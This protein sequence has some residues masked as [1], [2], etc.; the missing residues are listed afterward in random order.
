MCTTGGEQ[1]SECE[2]ASTLSTR[3][4]SEIAVVHGFYPSEKQVKW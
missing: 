2:V 4:L 1:V 3:V